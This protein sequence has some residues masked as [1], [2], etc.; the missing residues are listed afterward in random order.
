M[1][2]PPKRSSTMRK[3][4]NGT[5]RTYRIA[6]A[7]TAEYTSFWGDDDDSNG[8]NPRRCFGSSC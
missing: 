4:H 1:E 8:T 6:V 7:G 5:L 3:R 2:N